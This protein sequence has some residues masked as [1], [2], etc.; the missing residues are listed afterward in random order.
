MNTLD[1]GICLFA[2]F[3][4]VRGLFRGLVLELTG[5]AGLA[6]GIYLAGNY[7]QLAEPLVLKVFTDPRFVPLVAF[8]LVFVA[9]LAVSGF[10]G[11]ILRRFLTATSLTWADYITGGVF[12]LLKG[13]AIAAVAIVALTV[14]MPSA[15][16]LTGSLLRPY[17]MPAA[18]LVAEYLPD[19]LEASYR[20]GRVLLPD[21]PPG[22][23]SN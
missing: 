2:A 13:A 19:G 18:D 15:G 10:I 17:L 11:V 1:I 23:D 5:I 12:G 4:V 20:R 16:W 9:V 7:S 3:F 6:A 14:I 8:L 22:Q 21:A